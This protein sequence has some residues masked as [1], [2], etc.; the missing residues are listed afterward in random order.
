MRSTPFVVALVVWAGL[1]LASVGA[2][3]TVTGL[4][5]HNVTLNEGAGVLTITG[6][7]FGREL[8]VTVD[9]QP[10]A[11]AH[12]TFMP[13]VEARSA[14]QLGPEA[15]GETDGSGRYSL[16]TVF[17]DGGAS[18]GKNRVMVSTRKTE[19]DPTNPDRSKEVAKERVPGRYFTEQA[20][21]IFE[22]PPGGSKAANFEL[23]T[24]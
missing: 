21:L 2:T 4:T 20:P 6:I 19:L 17:G 14:A 16:K 24:K 3:Q 18:V 11:A 10:L 22:V 5:I 12:V 15:A 1:G 7:G 13:L 8:L 23:T 9:G